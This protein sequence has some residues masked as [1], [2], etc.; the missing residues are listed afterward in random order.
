M[1]SG[2]FIVRFFSAV[3]RGVNGLRKILHLLLLLF[4]F[5]LFFGVMSGEAPPILPQKAALVVQPVG[6]L[7]E[8][9]SGNPYDRALAELLGET[10]PETVVQ[11][12]VNALEEAKDDPRIAAVHLELSALT[13]AGVDKLERVAAAIESFRNTGKPVVASADFYTQQGYFLAAH[14]DEVYLNPEGIVFLQGYGSYRDYFADAI[15]MLRIDWNVFRVGTHKSFVEP[16]TRMDMSPEDRASRLRLVRHLWS[17]YERHVVEARGLTDGAVEDYAQNLVAHTEAAGGD[18]AIAARDRGLVDDLLGRTELRDLLIGYVGTSDDDDATYS[19]VWMYEYLS[20]L[21]LRRATKVSAE[22]VAI[23]VASGSILDGSQPPGTIGG[24]STASL[25]KR[26]LDDESVKAVVLRVD[27]GGGSAFASEV[28]AEEV[29]KLQVAGKPVVASMGSVAAS[30]GYWISMDADRI[31]A[32]P[33]T[34]T[35]SIGIFGMFPTFQRTL[36]M[37]GVATDGVGTTPWSGQLRPDRE[38]SEEMKQLIQISINDGY[39]D[40]ISGVANGRDLDVGYVDQIG[41]G[42]VWTGEE[43]LANGLVDELGGLDAAI[44]GAAE[45]AGLY[46]YGEKLIEIEMSPTEKLLLDLLSIVRGAGIDLQ[47]LTSPPTMVEVFANRF[48]ELLARVARFNDP[49]G[50]YTYCFCEIP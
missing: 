20:Q 43:A 44:A 1:S 12:V 34:I 24:D 36:A 31:Y 38:M 49:L 7:V 41:Q 5:L 15:E 33:T 28:I 8:Q 9:L 35:G 47:A 22:N 25:L 50:R 42:Q 37:V 30:G 39:R 17:E 45:L 18:L 16:Y 27:S 2:N 14:A 21:A 48:E 4:I 19:G 32:S 6:R 29:R 10:Q 13:S 23:V 11:D 40:F 46:H 26:A 3:W